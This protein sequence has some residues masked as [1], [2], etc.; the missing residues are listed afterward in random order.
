MQKV[1]THNNLFQCMSLPSRPILDSKYYTRI[2]YRN[3][4]NRTTIDPRLFTC[5]QW[6]TGAKSRSCRE[7]AKDHMLKTGFEP[8]VFAL[9]MIRVRR[10]TAWPL[11][12]L[13]LFCCFFSYIKQHRKWLACSPRSALPLLGTSRAAS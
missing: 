7:K 4:V 11:E 12:L 10:L 5:S 2:L 3:E 1:A 13:M 6:T 8:V 9:R